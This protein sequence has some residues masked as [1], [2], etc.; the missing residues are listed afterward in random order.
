MN[1]NPTLETILNHRSIRKFKDKRLTTDQIHTIVK[2]AQQ[3]STSSHVMA[4]TII[5]VTDESIKADLAS[6]SGQPYVKDNGHLLIFCGDLN[7][8]KQQATLQEQVDMQETLESTEQFIVAAIDASLAAQNAALA[9]ESMGIGICFIGSI[10]NNIRRVNDILDLPD[11]VVPFFGLALGYPEQQPEKKPRLPIDVVYHENHYQG[12]DQQR[13]LIKDFDKS[14]AT[15]YENR[16]KN[17]RTDT[18][19][20]Q[21]IRKY[22][23][24]V[25]MDVSPYIKEK[26][27][28]RR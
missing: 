19:T 4:Y 10:R 9:A 2:A 13:E 7:R 12:T 24:A 11:H 25:R 23:N 3:A 5:G 28:N 15:Y 14:L 8:I 17:S 22:S 27:F 18:W 16:S 1:N 6:I 26:K 20:E 21:M